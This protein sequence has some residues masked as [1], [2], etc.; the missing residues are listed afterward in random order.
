M[1][2]TQIKI[3]RNTYQSFTIKPYLKGGLKDSSPPKTITAK[4]TQFW[5]GNGIET[6]EYDIQKYF[7]ANHF[8]NSS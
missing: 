7:V 2:C 4:K 6:K 3:Q 5:L 1:R 8:K